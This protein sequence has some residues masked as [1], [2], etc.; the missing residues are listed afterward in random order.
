MDNKCIPRMNM[1]LSLPKH[2]DKDKESMLNRQL[3]SKGARQHAMPS[4]KFG[5]CTSDYEYGY[6]EVS[7][8]FNTHSSEIY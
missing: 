7:Y 4:G 6:N 5:C 2:L 1:A 3:Q 8:C